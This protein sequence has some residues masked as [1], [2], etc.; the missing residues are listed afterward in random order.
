MQISELA[1]TKQNFVTRPVDNELIL[2]PLRK[3]VADMTEI[4]N[5]NEVGHFI[6]NEIHEGATIE[7]LTEKI[8][9]EYE[10]ESAVAQADLEA[11]LKDLTNFILND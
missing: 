5:L 9:S 6:W 4:F 11:F 3:N 7:S 8:V 2:V 10:V 1:K